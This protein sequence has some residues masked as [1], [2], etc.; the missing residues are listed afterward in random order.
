M[1]SDAAVLAALLS[2][3][4]LGAMVQLAIL[5]SLPQMAVYFSSAGGARDGTIIAQLVT[6]IAAPGM[7]LG[8]PLAGW[9][10]ERLGRR[11]VFLTATIVYALAGVAGAV[12]PSLGLLLLSRLMLGLAAG[13]V[14]AIG[15]ALIGTFRPLT[16]RDSLLGWYSFIGSA[17]AF[18]VLLAAGAL[19]SV[20]WK[21]PF[22]LYLAGL[23]TLGIA[24]LTIEEEPVGPVSTREDTGSI[25]PAFRYFAAL[26]L[27]SLIMYMASI[28]GPFLLV[29]WGTKAPTAQAIF[30][31][32][33]TA[34]GLI[35]AFLF[36]RVRRV[37]AFSTVF[38]GI[39]IAFGVSTIGLGLTGN[40]AADLVFG[41]L[42]GLGGGLLAPLMKSAVMDAVEPKAV[43]R[44]VGMIVGCLFLGQFVQ[45]FAIAPFRLAFGIQQTFI[46]VGTAS[47]VIG[48]ALLV[49]AIVGR[50]LHVASA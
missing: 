24:G 11:R 43:G 20:H 17:G 31:D 41:L 42:C 33:I 7:F 44:S 30:A 22:L 15:V 1:R 4:V 38:A 40:F 45:P 8:A 35:G 16:R 13:A 5:P 3:A 9:A 2:T 36:G 34:G 26:L 14:S 37:A 29:S 50:R 21:L 32:A 6:T 39:W 47:L 27:I 28:Q 10:A 46:G 12:A 18:C 25:R 49:R 48:A 19:S 23:A